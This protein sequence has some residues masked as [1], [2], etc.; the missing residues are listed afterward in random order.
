MA[1]AGEGEMLLKGKMIYYKDL[2]LNSLNIKLQLMPTANHVLLSGGE[3][4]KCEVVKS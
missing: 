4:E 2:T 3:K 1:K